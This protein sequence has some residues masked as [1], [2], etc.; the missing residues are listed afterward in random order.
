MDL[1]AIDF[2][3]FL[4]NSLSLCFNIVKQIFLFFHVFWLSRNFRTSN[5]PN[6]FATLFFREIEDREKNKSTGNAMR[7]ERGGTMQA[8]LLATC[9]G[10]YFP[11]VR[12]FDTV[13]DSTYSS[14]PKPTIYTPRWRLHDWPAE[15]HKI[16]SKHL[17]TTRIEGETL[18]EPLSIADEG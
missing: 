16:Y 4:N 2:G 8:H 5:G 15:K 10:T 14:W 9:G 13:L 7:Q 11:L 12:C 18:S 6:I 3:G 1:F 17:K